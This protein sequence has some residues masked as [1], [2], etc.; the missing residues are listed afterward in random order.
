M[1]LIYKYQ[2]GTRA[3]SDNTSVVQKKFPKSLAEAKIEGKKTI[4]AE[5]K[6]Q[7]EQLV[8]ERNAEAK[9]AKYQKDLKEG[10]IP[11]YQKKTGFVNNTPEEKIGMKGELAKLQTVKNQRSTQEKLDDAA[12]EVMTSVIPE[13]PLLKYIKP[14]S[15]VVEK[16]IEKKIG[17]KLVPNTQKELNKANKDA[18]LFSQSIFNKKKLEEFRPNQKFSVTNQKARFIDDPKALNLYEKYKFENDP[19]LSINQYLGNNRGIYGAKDYGDLNDV[20]L[21]N[22]SAPHTPNVPSKQVYTDAMHETTH[23]RSIRLGATDAEKQIASDAWQPMIKKN[24]FNLPEEEAF[25]V[26]NELRT[27]KLKD[28]KGDRVYTDKDIPEIKQGLQKM[29]N[30]GHDYLKGTN[31]EDFNMPALIKSLNKIGL[32][33]TIPA[34]MSVQEKRKGGLIYK[35][36]AG[37]KVKSD[38]YN[39]E[40]NPKE[41]LEF[42]SWYSKISKH[43]NLNPNPDDE[44]QHYDYRGFWKNNKNNDMLKKDT[45]SHFT[46]TYK[47][48]GHPTFSDESIYS[49][50]NTKGG[51]WSESKEGVFYFTHSPYTAKY[52]EK[53][54]EYLKGTG[55]HSILNNDTIYSN[56]PQLLKR[57]KK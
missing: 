25:A 11:W 29:I 7:A 34:V 47:K 15:K 30:E 43:K 38:N 14:T 20:V 16:A 49:T 31:I 21:I 8:A 55:E 24:D 1:A 41:E 9:E 51:K 44:N 13:L 32:A 33:A 22:K 23:S 39:T 57:V 12:L 19:N 10:N 48:P 36:Q 6:K 37:N 28:I 46:D 42:K 53:T 18:E 40:L 54:A 3:V 50:D 52:A 17:I 5:A 2:Q 35:Y 4:E 56:K 27:D 26:Q 45:Y